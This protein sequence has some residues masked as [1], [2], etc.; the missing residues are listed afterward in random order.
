MPQRCRIMVS[1]TGAAIL[2]STAPVALVRVT[3]ASYGVGCR[4]VS[5]IPR[6][7]EGKSD[8]R[9]NVGLSEFESDRKNHHELG[10]YTVGIRP[11]DGAF[12]RRNWNLR[13][14]ILAGEG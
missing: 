7:N 3:S 4:D 11:C 10:L 12:L 2:H 6:S 9:Q 13:F 14:R 5:V 1:T 8:V